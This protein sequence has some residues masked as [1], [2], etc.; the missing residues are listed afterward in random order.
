VQIRRWEECLRNDGLREGDLVTLV[1]RWPMHVGEIDFMARQAAILAV[2]RGSS[3]RP[4]L[5]EVHEVIGRHR[6][7][8]RTPVLFGRG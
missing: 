7:A 4:G 8:S 1:E 6:S 3:G 2:I 5:A